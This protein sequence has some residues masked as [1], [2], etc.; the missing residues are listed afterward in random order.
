MSDDSS[1]SCSL[2]SDSG[3]LGKNDGS[4]TRPLND[5]SEGLPLFFPNLSLAR[6]FL[7]KLSLLSRDWRMAERGSLKSS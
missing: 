6:P 1:I 7:M 2:R 5:R 3:S 4:L